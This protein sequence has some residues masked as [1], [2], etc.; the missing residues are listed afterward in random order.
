MNQLLRS[1]HRRLVVSGFYPRSAL[2]RFTAWVAGL[3]VISESLALAIPDSSKWSG[4]FGGWA[5]FFEFVAIICGAFLLLR[6][7]RRKLLWR[8]RNRLIVTYV[9]IGVIPVVLI[10]C[11]VV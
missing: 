6:W 11:M 9:F 8:L 4:I 7:I 3:Y 2:S 1:A 10:L 5:G